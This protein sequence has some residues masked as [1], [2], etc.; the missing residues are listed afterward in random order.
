MKCFLVSFLVCC[1]ASFECLAQISFGLKA[2][3]GWGGWNQSAGWAL[4]RGQTAEHKFENAY[5]L[6]VNT[7][8]ALR[9]NFDFNL[10]MS[11]V[12][13]GSE[14]EYMW[15][16]VIH[17]P[18]GEPFTSIERTTYSVNIIQAPVSFSY[19]LP[20]Q[21][22]RPY[23][24]IGVSPLYQLSGSRTY[25]S[26]LSTTNELERK[27]EKLNYAKE[28]NE[29]LQFSVPMNIALGVRLF[30]RFSIEGNFT[31]ASGF[32]YSLVPDDFICPDECGDSEWS[33]ANRS[34]I[35]ALTYQFWNLPKQATN[36]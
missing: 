28:R 32:V 1:I 33:F 25:F 5:L 8:V 3:K 35:L 13:S 6:G 12:H 27:S 30:E 21:N 4:Q 15:T 24:K 9:E 23:I 26:Y 14:F 22:Y 17:Q 18:T 29:G 20:G 36:Q 10:E 7:R 11:Y 34:I 16:G 2:G 19:S 31:L